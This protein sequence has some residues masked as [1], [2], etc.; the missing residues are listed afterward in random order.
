MQY[1]NNIWGCAIL[2]YVLQMDLES[3]ILHFSVSFPTF[4]GKYTFQSL[5]E[6]VAHTLWDEKEG[7]TSLLLFL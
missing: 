2:I 4:H 5:K 3:G 7:I 1:Q 6:E